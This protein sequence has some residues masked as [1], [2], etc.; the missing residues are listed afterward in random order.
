MDSDM[1]MCVMVEGG[2]MVQGVLV[3]GQS[4]E[5]GTQGRAW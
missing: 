3:S 4:D 2:H 5:L 1:E